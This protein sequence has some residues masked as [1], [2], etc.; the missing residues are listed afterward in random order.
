MR[1]TTIRLDE[2]LHREAKALAARRG[3]TLTRL[4]KEALREE[5]RKDEAGPERE[6]IKLPSSGHGG[7]R[8]GVNLN[9]WAELLDLME[10]H[11]P[12]GR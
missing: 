3:M 4:L 10:E 5:L 11:D 7:V 2:D 1:T 8:P 6:R 9:S 12:P